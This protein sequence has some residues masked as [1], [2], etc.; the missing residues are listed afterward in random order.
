MELARTSPAE[1]GRAAVQWDSIGNRMLRAISRPGA[2]AWHAIDV[3]TARTV[4]RITSARSLGDR[5]ALVRIVGNDLTGRHDTEQSIENTK[6]ILENEPAFDNCEKVWILN[7]IVDEKMERRLSLMLEDA[8]R[9][10]IRIP[11][12]AD[13][14]SAVSNDDAFV[15][16]DFMKSD[17]LKALDHET[18]LRA[19]MAFYRPKML[20]IMNVNA[21]RNVAIEALRHEADWI[22]PWDGNCFLTAAGWADLAGSVLRNQMFDYH[23]VPM[24][25]VVRNDEVLAGGLGSRATEEPQLV[26][27]RTAQERFDPAVPYARRNKVEL[28]FRLG[29][30]GP[31]KKLKS[32][33]W[34]VKPRPR[35][36]SHGLFNPRAGWVARLSSGN[37]HLE[38][39]RHSPRLRY[40]QR[41]SAAL[42]FVDEV[43]RKHGRPGLTVGSLLEAN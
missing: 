28:L 11:F 24:V 21:A 37:P 32:D 43:D 6:F 8:G 29:I 31:E 36:Q 35:S 3:A 38:V 17:A 39:G 34:D 18:Q 13:E 10:V 22:M 41:I 23:A 40:S 7:R 26:F 12:V 33:P 4:H 14:Y 30:F 15:S 1:T 2:R 16:A 42:R 20:Y 27:S 19:M 9:R 25:R 5:F